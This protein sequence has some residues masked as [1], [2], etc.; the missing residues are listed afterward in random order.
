MGLTDSSLQVLRKDGQLVLVELTHRIGLMA[1]STFLDD[2]FVDFVKDLLGQQGFEQWMVQHPQE[3]SKLKCKAWE[4]AKL[5]FD[6]TD[7]A[8][9]DPPFSL[10]KSLPDKVRSGIK[11]VM[12]VGLATDYVQY[13]MWPK[14]L[15]YV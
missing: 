14:L 11:Q 10:L 9:I 8:T 2:H 4:E 6:G 1:G 15:R 7:A 3:F 5:A 12:H 13:L